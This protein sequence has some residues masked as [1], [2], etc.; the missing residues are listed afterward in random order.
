MEPTDGPNRTG[1][2]LVF[3]ILFLYRFEDTY[4]MIHAINLR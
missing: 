3:G 2:I 4:Y 1:D